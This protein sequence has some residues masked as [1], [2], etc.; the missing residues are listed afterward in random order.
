[1]RLLSALNPAYRIQLVWPSST[2]SGLP[3]R[4]HTGTPWSSESATATM[5]LPS[6]LNTADLTVFMSPSSTATCLPS[7]SHK[8]AVPSTDAVTIRLPSGLNSACQ[9]L[10]VWPDSTAS[11]RRPIELLWEGG[12]LEQEAS[13]ATRSAL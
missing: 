12:C 3:S 2:V 1:M 5:R 6:G 4:S 13:S 8:R 10:S 9:T 11:G 7:V